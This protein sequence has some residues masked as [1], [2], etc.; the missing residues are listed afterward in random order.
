MLAK[1]EDWLESNR[2][3]GRTVTKRRTYILAGEVRESR[4]PVRKGNMQSTKTSHFVERLQAYPDQMIQ[5]CESGNWWVAQCVKKQNYEAS[6]TFM[7]PFH[8]KGHSSQAVRHHKARCDSKEQMGRRGRSITRGFLRKCQPPA[9]EGVPVATKDKS[10]RTQ[11]RE[12]YGVGK[13]GTR[14]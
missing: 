9:C 12:D 14:G 3:C 13:T 6:R 7:C 5:N 10:G 2:A 1:R 4:S 8:L 11:H